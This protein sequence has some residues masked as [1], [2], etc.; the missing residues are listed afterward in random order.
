M[1]VTLPPD[2]ES[3][4]AEKLRAEGISPEAY[5]ERLNRKAA[6]HAPRKTAPLP[7]WSGRALSDL[8]R[9]DLYDDVHVKM[10]DMDEEDA[11]IYVSYIARHIEDTR[12][13]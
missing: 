7:A 3:R 8:R 11:V 10:L 12:D 1:I 2:L 4:V 6:A 13:R 5:V 9:K